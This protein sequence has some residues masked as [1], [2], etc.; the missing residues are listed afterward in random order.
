MSKRVFHEG[1]IDLIIE[2]ETLSENMKT[3]G[4]Y[5]PL[6]YSSW[7]K[8]RA[9]VNYHDRPSPQEFCVQDKIRA[10]EGLGPQKGPVLSRLGKKIPTVNPNKLKNFTINFNSDDQPRDFDAESLAPSS[11]PLPKTQRPRSEWRGA[12]HRLWKSMLS[13]LEGSYWDKV[14]N[15]SLA[16][17]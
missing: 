4:R 17:L 11:T 16:Q 6:S 1:E 7:C 9:V 12:K 10:W 14:D 8:R 3:G 15:L 5:E 2:Y 13:Q